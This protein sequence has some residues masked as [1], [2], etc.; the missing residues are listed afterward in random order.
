MGNGQGTAA[1][2]VPHEN[3]NQNHAKTFMNK[4]NNQGQI[5]GLPE[6]KVV[7]PVVFL[8]ALVVEIVRVGLVAVA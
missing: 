6:G 7:F 2:G 5:S 8:V 1:G 3:I 4:P